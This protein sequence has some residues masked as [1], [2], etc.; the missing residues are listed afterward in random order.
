[1]NF[2]ELCNENL[3]IQDNICAVSF[4]NKDELVILT[5]T[6]EV[7]LYHLSSKKLELLFET[8]PNNGL[9]YADGGFDPTASSSIYTMDSIIVVVNDYK[10]HGFVLNRKEG[11]RLHISRGDYHANISKYPIALFEAANGDP[12]LIYGVDWNH[13]QIANLTT[14][15]VLTAD[16]SL[17]EEDAEQRH[18]DFYKKH[19]ESNKLLWPRGYDY[20]FARL[21]LSPD[22]KSFLSAGWVWGSC[23][24]FNLYNIEDFITNHRIKHTVIGGWEHNDRGA[25]FVDDETVA[26]VYN[27]QE[28]GE[29]DAKNAYDLRLYH[30]D[31]QG[32]K[33]IITLN[34]P[35]N[36][37]GAELFYRTEDQNFYVF[38]QKIGMAVISRSG[39]IMF[40]DST[41]IPKRYDDEQNLFIDYDE[42]RIRIFRIE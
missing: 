23:D 22:K 3:N 36:L 30:T 25:C 27:P 41:F 32:A 40:C 31:G 17:I 8:N 9:K 39:D 1:L 7:L 10:K 34:P 16:K 11:Y 20:F 24:C 21:M 26:I 5:C 12:H 33:G 2:I 18:I 19:K 6:G 35:L 13:L 4:C 38:S 14:R 37:S 15:Q 28:E 42:K 29:S